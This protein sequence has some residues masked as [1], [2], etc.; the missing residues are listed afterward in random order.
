MQEAYF[1]DL[2]EGIFKDHCRDMS[3]QEIATKYNIDI[4][5]VDD[6]IRLAKQKY[7]IIQEYTPDLPPRI[8]KSVR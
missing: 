5:Y 6:V 7:D 2:Q 1:S 8:K 4:G 3:R